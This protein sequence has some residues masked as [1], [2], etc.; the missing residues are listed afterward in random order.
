MLMYSVYAFNDL[1]VRYM[2]CEFDLDPSDPDLL[3]RPLITRFVCKKFALKSGDLVALVSDGVT[4]NVDDKE[5]IEHVNPDPK[6]M[7]K[8]LLNIALKNSKDLDK[9]SPFGKAFFKALE[10]GDR[11]A[12]YMKDGFTARYG[13]VDGH[14]IGGKQDDMA[15]VFYRHP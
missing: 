9:I 14:L 12:R 4:G 7:V 11:T 15:M 3:G 2:G 13:A 5:M 8:D 10:A 6:I 1:H